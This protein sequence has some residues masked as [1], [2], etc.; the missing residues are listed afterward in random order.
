MEEEKIDIKIVGIKDIEEIIKKDIENGRKSIEEKIGIKTGVIKKC[1]FKPTPHMVVRI[2]DEDIWLDGP[3]ES[4]EKGDYVEGTLIE[5]K[6]KNIGTMAGESDLGKIEEPLPSYVADYV[7]IISINKNEKTEE[8]KIGVIKK[9]S[10]DEDGIHAIVK[11]GDEDIFIEGPIG[12]FEKGDYVEGTWIWINGKDKGTI[13]GEW[14]FGD[15]G[16][17]P[18]FEAEKIRIIEGKKKKR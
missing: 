16:I 3:I 18:L 4:F 17:L 14:E 10:F 1:S 13:V 11:I 15:L 8:V 6:G 12:T 5:I 7:R 9:S 2:G